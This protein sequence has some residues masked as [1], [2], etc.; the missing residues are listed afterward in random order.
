VSAF[1]TH[2]RSFDKL[3]E[4]GALSG[5]LELSN[6]K[7]RDMHFGSYDLTDVTT[8]D[9]SHNGLQEIPVDLGD[10]FCI[11]SLNLSYNSIKMVP[12]F[13]INFKLIQML[14]LS[15]NSIENIPPSVCSLVCLQIL[16]IKNNR[17]LA[18]PQAI[19]QLKNCQELDVSNNR[20]Q[21]LPNEMSQMSSLYY[22]NISVNMIESL[23]DALSS[24]PII[25]LDAHC[26]RLSEIPLSFQ[27]LTSLEVLDV[28]ENPM[29]FPS[30]KVLKLGI[31][32]IL[33]SLQNR[34]MKIQKNMTQQDS[35]LKSRQQNSLETIVKNISASPQRRSFSALP[36]GL[37]NITAPCKDGESHEG[38]EMSR[39]NTSTTGRE[40]QPEEVMKDFDDVCNNNHIGLTSVDGRSSSPVLKNEYSLQEGTKTVPS[41]LQKKTSIPRLRS[42]SSPKSPVTSEQ[43]QSTRRRSTTNYPGYSPPKHPIGSPQHAQFLKVLKVR[44]AHNLQTSRKAPPSK[45]DP[46]FTLRRKTEK[47][48][49]ELE[50]MEKL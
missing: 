44:K 11:R 28:H 2:V 3:L 6:Q 46:S 4:D 19:G 21:C 23:P 26:N 31:V 27:N 36:S 38:L 33:K 12:D 16:R 45:L 8:V 47:L 14:D 30:F 15:N 48:Y 40:L 7:M 49:E 17:L 13:V 32:H 35:F 37:Q 39:C 41:E 29:T 18:L 9:L 5:R 24:L 20:L 1:N 34:S 22:L 25:R 42:N 50:L 43:K 10:W